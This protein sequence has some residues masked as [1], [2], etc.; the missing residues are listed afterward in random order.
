M[1]LGRAAEVEQRKVVLG[2]ETER[3]MKELQRRM[4]GPGIPLSP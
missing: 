4:L 1:D 3:R 2:R